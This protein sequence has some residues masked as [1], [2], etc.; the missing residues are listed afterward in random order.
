M[1]GLGGVRMGV[2]WVG[3]GKGLRNPGWGREALPRRAGGYMGVVWLG[4]IRCEEGLK[5]LEAFGGEVFA[6]EGVEGGAEGGGCHMEGRGVGEEDG[7]SKQR[8]WGWWS[9]ERARRR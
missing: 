4:G 1:R 8:A 2:G 5:K 7:T 6:G 9:A 3:D